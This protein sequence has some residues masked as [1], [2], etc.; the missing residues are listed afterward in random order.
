MRYKEIKAGFVLN[1]LVKQ[2]TYSNSMATGRLECL[3][4][5]P[6]IQASL[7]PHGLLL[8]LDRRRQRG[9]HEPRCETWGARVWRRSAVAGGLLSLAGESGANIVQPAEAWQSSESF[10]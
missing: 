7:R 6:S 3:S 1:E 8:V 10:S 9:S 2:Q 4:S 5:I